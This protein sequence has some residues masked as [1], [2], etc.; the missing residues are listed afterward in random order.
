[1][2]MIECRG[3]FQRRATYLRFGDFRRWM[4]GYVA[5]TICP[6]GINELFEGIGRAGVEVFGSTQTSPASLPAKL[7][8]KP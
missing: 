3:P 5:L 2:L 4:W 8:E 1:M 7:D 6:Y